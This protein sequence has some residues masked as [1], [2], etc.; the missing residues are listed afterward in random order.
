MFL[1]VQKIIQRPG[2]YSSAELNRC[3]LIRSRPYPISLHPFSPCLFKTYTIDLSVFLLYDWTLISLPPLG[4][5]SPP[6]PPPLFLSSITCYQQEPLQLFSSPLFSD[7]FYLFP[8][9]P[10]SFAVSLTLLP[11]DSEPLSYLHPPHTSVPPPDR[12][13]LIGRE[14]DTEGASWSFVSR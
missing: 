3:A 1:G 12:V 14:I 13:T 5:V 8:S 7:V 2:L 9:P 11:P 10:L 4:C 6:P